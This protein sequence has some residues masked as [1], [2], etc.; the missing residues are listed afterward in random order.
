MTNKPW[1]TIHPHFD[2][3]GREWETN[4][5]TCWENNHFTY[6][7]TKNWIDSGLNPSELEF[8]LWLKN[9]KQLDPL[10]LTKPEELETLRKE[11][12]PFGE[13]TEYQNNQ[14]STEDKDQ[15]INNLKEQISQLETTLAESKQ[16]IDD[17]NIAL[18]HQQTI[19]GK[20]S[21]GKMEL[22]ADYN[23]LEKTNEELIKDN[24]NLKLSLNN[25]NNL[26]N[27]NKHLRQEIN[28]LKDQN[29]PEL[30][31]KKEAKT[32]LKR[33][34]KELYL[35]GQ[36]S[37]NSPPKYPKIN[38]ILKRCLNYCSESRIKKNGLWKQCVLEEY[39]NK[40]HITKEHHCDQII[41]WDFH[42]NGTQSYSDFQTHILPY[43][44]QIR[45]PNFTKFQ[46]FQ[47]QDWDYIKFAHQAKLPWNREI[48]PYSLDEMAEITPEWKQD[49]P[50]ELIYNYVYLKEIRSQISYKSQSWGLSTD[51]AMARYAD[52]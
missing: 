5:Q 12:N 26:E 32:I 13:T 45:L 11:F 21:K 1:K 49:I 29:T 37:I 9:D 15:T 30:Q 3:Q 43:L 16:E 44:S 4:Y 14:A 35:K 40:C 36:K 52:Y 6:E 27:E 7:Q 17:L 48:Y 10:T 39:D 20:A 42:F 51:K 23:S 28:C 46:D 2:Y 25:L 50:S 22:I 38:D 8:C 18:L 24:E 33:K 47:P 19:S 31:L 34:E 41:R